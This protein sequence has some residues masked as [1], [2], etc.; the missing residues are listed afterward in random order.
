MLGL[1]FLDNNATNVSE[2]INIAWGPNDVEAPR[3]HEKARI[4]KTG[5]VFTQ[6][7]DCHGKPDQHLKC[8]DKGCFHEH[9]ELSRGI[10]A[11]KCKF[12]WHPYQGRGSVSGAQK[13]ACLPAFEGADRNMSHLLRA[14]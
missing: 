6:Q 8:G 7:P 11:L 10:W 12:P 4:L 3:T 1:Q 9:A 13:G 5:H 14:M 2:K